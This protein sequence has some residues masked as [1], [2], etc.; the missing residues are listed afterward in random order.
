MAYNS[1]RG[2]TRQ[3][4]DFR[5]KESWGGD[6]KE[7]TRF[8]GPKRPFGDSAQKDNG[9]VDFDKVF[10]A[11]NAEISAMTDEE[12]QNI[13]KK[14]DMTIT[15]DNIPKPCMQFNNTG[16]PA[17]ILSEFTRSGYTEPTP[18]QAQGW[19][20]ALTGRNMVGV[21]N[22]GSGKTLSFILP[23]MI[24]AKAQQALR[25]GDGPIVLVLA[26]TRELVSQIEEE[27]ARYAKFFGLSSASVFGGVASGPQKAALRRGVEILIATPGRLIDLYEQKALYLSR[28]TFLVLDEADRML[29]MGFEPQLKKIIP[30]TNPQ[31]QTLMWSATWPEGVKSLARSYMKEYIQVKIGSA[32]LVANAK[33]IQKTFIVDHWEKDKTLSEILTDISGNND[34]NPRIIIFCNQKRRCDELVDKMQEY[35]WP[36]EA[37]HGDKAQNQRDRII[38]DFK[39]G[40]RTVLVATDVAARGLDVKDVKAV[41]NYDFPINCEDYIHRIGRTARGN[42]EEG[43]SYTFFSPKD[44]RGNAKKYVE[45]LKETNQ[46]IPQ[47][48]FTLGASRGGTGG[49]NRRYG[50]SSSFGRGRGG[51]GKW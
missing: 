21:A 5:R 40:R 26:P 25:P 30:E 27:T 28:V 1:F 10:Y 44:D 51:S 20:M 48:L 32:D 13:R 43:Y 12:V 22:T 15:G 18:I 3:G 37:L 11:E 6:R 36:A 4:G 50:G 9:P 2:A 35:G 31:R 47:Q 45:I 29:D 46:E 14:F 23:A 49:G 34:Q 41:V 33:I 16:F 38:S 42:C 39:I 19:P 8:G 7:N 17:A 24:H